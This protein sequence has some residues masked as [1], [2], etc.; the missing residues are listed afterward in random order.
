M[1][2][3]GREIFPL[4]IISSD[5]L[6]YMLLLVSEVVLCIARDLGTQK[7]NLY[8]KQY[9]KGPTELLAMATT[10]LL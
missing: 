1:Y 6:G 4:S 10:W 5:P 2:T 3:G 7:V 8:S 9:L